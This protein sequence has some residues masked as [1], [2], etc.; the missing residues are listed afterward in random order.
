MWQVVKA[1]TVLSFVLY[2][3][4]TFFQF[5]ISLGAQVLIWGIL[6]CGV[7]GLRLSLKAVQERL[8]HAPK[9]SPQMERTLVIG[10]GLAGQMLIKE[11]ERHPEMNSRI[12]D[13]WM[14]IPTS[15]KC[16]S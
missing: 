11:L 2:L 6:L 15:K 1:M 5:P 12:V 16:F 7:A 4:I 10:A 3:I 14:M 9:F 13:F 8:I